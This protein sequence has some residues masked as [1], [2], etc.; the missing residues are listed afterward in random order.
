M[1]YPPPYSF[2]YPHAAFVLAVSS[3]VKVLWS[4]LLLKIVSLIMGDVI[5]FAID[6][7]RVGF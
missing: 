3:V 2:V 4:R 6:E 1:G 5:G 7:A